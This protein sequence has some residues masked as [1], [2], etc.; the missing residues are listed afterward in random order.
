MVLTARHGL[1]IATVAMVLSTPRVVALESCPNN[2]RSVVDRMRKV[3]KPAPRAA[4]HRPISTVPT[5]THGAGDAK[6]AQYGY[7]AL[8]TFMCIP[9]SVA[10]RLPE[11]PSDPREPC[12]PAPALRGQTTNV[13]SIHRDLACD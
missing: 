4:N 12:V 11:G 3:R 2:Y 9:R 1:A 13:A 10:N 6:L 5:I 7:Y 8:P